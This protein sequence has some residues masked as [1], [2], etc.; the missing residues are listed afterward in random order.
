[1]CAL[2]AGCGGSEAPD[3]ARADVQRVLD[4]R[5]EAV[6][7][8]DESAY[9]GTEAPVADSGGLATGLAEF[10]NL[11]GLPLASW[12]YRLTGFHRSGDRA[13][14][15]AELRYRVRGYDRAPVTAARALTLTRDD[16]SW[17]VA[18]DE[19]AREAAEQLWEQ[20]AVRAVRGRHSLVLGVGR[21]EAEL[22]TY[23]EAADRAV[24]AVSGAWGDDWAERVVVLVPES[25]EEMAGLL[26]APASGYRGIAAVTTGETGGSGRTP[27]DRIVVNPDAYA[28]LGDFGGQV[29]LTHEATH[30]ATR[31]HTTAA[32]PLWLS[33]GYADWVGYRSAGRTPA[34][35]APELQREVREGRVPDALPDDEDFGFG[36]DANGLAMAYEGGWLACRMIADRWGEERLNAFYRA[37]GGHERRAGAVEDALRDVLG[38]TP[39]RFTGQWREYLRDQL[40]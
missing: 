20:G 29:V 39:A 19:P 22:R 35:I 28:V 4:R 31:A 30:V 24:P 25:L 16:G 13:T 23:A 2:V 12:S 5:A 21:T 38:T 18:S 8:R 33:E 3:P 36:R 10:A 32:T 27:A 14:A 6:L 7:A 11:R 1:M 9:R 37:V 15:E 26:G 34:Q 40:G 17:Y